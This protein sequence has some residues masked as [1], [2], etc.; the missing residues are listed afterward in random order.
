[1]VMSEL[2]RLKKES[3]EWYDNNRHKGYYQHECP[4]W[5]DQHNRAIKMQRL[6]ERLNPPEPRDQG[7]DSMTM[8]D[9]LGKQ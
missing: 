9:F 3:Q 5:T 1:M 8:E 2:Q 4:G 6:N 7:I